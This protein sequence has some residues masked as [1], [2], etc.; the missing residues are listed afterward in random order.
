MIANRVKETT[1]TAT[2]GDLTLAGAFSAD[3]QTFNTGFGLNARFKYWIVDETNNVWETGI[4]Y[5]SGTTTLVRETVLD[6]SSNTQVALT[7][8]AGTKDVFC[9]LGEGG[10][11]P[12]IPY[13][14]D[15]GSKYIHNALSGSHANVTLVADRMYYIP[16]WYIYEG[17]VD[18]IACN[19]QVAAG[20]LARIGIYEYDSDGNPGDILI[21]SADIDSSTT[22]IKVSTFTSQIRRPGWYYHGIMCDGAAAFRGEDYNYTNPCNPVGCVNTTWRESGVLYEDIASGWTTLP[23]TAAAA[24][25]IANG[26]AAR[27]P[28]R[29]A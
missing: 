5:L 20:T 13:M 6:N 9:T 2:N 11:V 22:G 16:F 18:A 21:E 23:A 29:A 19:V 14:S 7:L 8:S 24:P 15:R 12:T 26:G 28:L 27:I 10:I 4:G 3:F 17:L 25:D 1:T